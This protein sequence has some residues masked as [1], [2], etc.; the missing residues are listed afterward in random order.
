MHDVYSWNGIRHHRDITFTRSPNDWE[1]ERIISLLSFLADLYAVG[2][3][4]GD[5]KIIWSLTSCGIFS[6]KHL[7]ERMIRSNHPHLPD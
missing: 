2:L 1:E 7:C 5:D 3:P 4:E 6:V